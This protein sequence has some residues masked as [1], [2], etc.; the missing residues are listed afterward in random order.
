M[1]EEEVAAKL[2]DTLPKSE[3]LDVAYPDP[4][5]DDPQSNDNFV[6]KMLPE[7]RLTQ[8]KLLDYFA[9]PSNERHTPLVDRWINEVYAWARDNAGEG[10]FNQ[11]LRVINEQELHMGSKLKPGRLSRLYQYIRIAQI[12]KDLADKERLLYG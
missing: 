11:L 8:L 6:D 3:P 4:P 7:E 10:G 2:A 5:V 1:N 12:R 9:V